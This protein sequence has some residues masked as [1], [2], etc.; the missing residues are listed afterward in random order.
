MCAPTNGFAFCTGDM[1]SLGKMPKKPGYLRQLIRYEGERPV[2]IVGKIMAF[3]ENLGHSVTLEKVL[4]Q[5]NAGNCF[6][7]DYLPAERDT[8]DVNRNSARGKF[9]Y[10]II[11]YTNGRWQ[12]GCNPGFSSVEKTIETGFIRVT[13]QIV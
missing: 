1:K 9:G 8:L 5:M 10:F 13:Q 11:I 12:K 6:D 4:E 7:F 2:T 3:S